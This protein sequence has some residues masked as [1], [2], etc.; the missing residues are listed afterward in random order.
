MESPQTNGAVEAERQEVPQEEPRGEVEEGDAEAADDQAEYEEWVEQLRK[1]LDE[2][3][4]YA[5]LRDMCL[6]HA[7]EIPPSYRTRIWKIC[8]GVLRKPDALASWDGSLECLDREAITQ[9][10]TSQGQKLTNVDEEERAAIVEDM[11]ATMTFYC[12]SKNVRFRSDSGWAELLL[13]IS[14]LRP[15]RG[16]MYNILYT[17]VQKYVPRDCRIDGKPFHLFRLLLLYHD[18]ELCSFLDTKRISPD[19]YLQ[20][21]L[22]SLFAATCPLDVT[23]AMWDKYLLEADPF[24]VFFLALVILVNSKETLLADTESGQRGLAESIATF[25]CL[26]GSEDIDDFCQLAQHYAELTPQSF[27]MDYHAP[28]F[29]HVIPKT[30]F[31]QLSQTFCLPVGLTELLASLRRRLKPSS[32][33]CEVGYFVVDC[34]PVE[35]FRAGHLCTA[36]HLDAQLM[37]QNV[38]RFESLVSALLEMHDVEAGQDHWCFICTGHEEEDQYMNMAIAH[39]LKRGVSYV[40][41]AR[42]GYAALKAHFFDRVHDLLE[43]DG[44]AKPEI[45]LPTGGNGQHVQE[46]VEKLPGPEQ[47]LGQVKGGALVDRMVGAVRDR[48]ANMRSKLSHHIEARRQVVAERHALRQAHCHQPYRNTA[49]EFSIGGDEE[50]EESTKSPSASES[51]TEM[52]AKRR[53][54]NVRSF[55]DE[56][57]VMEMFECTEVKPDGFEVPARLVLTT[58]LLYILRELP[59]RPGYAQLHAQHSLTTLIKITSKRHRPEMITLRFGTV[60]KVQSM[61]RFIIPRAGA[62]CKAMKIAVLKE[63]DRLT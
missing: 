28:L 10:C 3:V 42:G 54:V 12:K 4:D 5:T 23:L 25:P 24:Q 51:D 52:A 14:V 20:V 45:I 27:R 2:S 36:H 59:D 39:F 35:Q 60:E 6:G 56:P 46:D 63:V 13:P 15:S 49:P 19:Q 58:K 8:L 22:R 11:R 29:G 44:P 62:A 1:A 26:L 50:D 17:V 53:T 55:C 16:D 61:R 48:T 38:A 30:S 21:W 37:L 57:D 31:G 47:G 32:E 40:S 7:H 33:A 18:P 41:A 43:A 9:H 34:R